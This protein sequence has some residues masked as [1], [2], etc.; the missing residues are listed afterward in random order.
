VNILMIFSGSIACGKACDA[1][2]RLVKAGHTVQTVA[3]TSA[4][5]FIGPALL[6]GISGRPCLRQL[7]GE[8]HQMDHLAWGRWADLVLVAPAT[9]NL[10]N[11]MAA[12][13]SDDLASCL[14]LA[15]PFPKPLWVAPAMNCRMWDHPATRATCRTLANWGV[16]FLGPQD[17]ALACGDIGPG[18]MMEAD[19]IAAAIA[20]LTA[21]APATQP[22]GPAVRWLI[23]AGGTEVPIDAVRCIGNTSTGQSGAQLADALARRGDSVTLLRAQRAASAT[24]SAV[25]NAEFRTPDDLDAAL[26][27]LLGDQPFDVV[28]HM[29]AV[30]D[31]SVA[32][33]EV[34][35]VNYPPSA[36]T[37]LQSTAD[38]R[39]VLR[40]APKI[41]DQLRGYGARRIVAFKLTSSD[42]PVANLEAA[43]RLFRNSGPDLVVLNNLA[44]VRPADDPL[45]HRMTL[46][47]AGE[48][49]AEL[50]SIE[51]L[52]HALVDWAHHSLTNSPCP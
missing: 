31:F 8:A 40:P 13:I 3:T 36:T 4:L 20:A 23:T 46:L 32:G 44:A 45:R 29:A 2:S 15:H 7:F 43:R 28:V 12:G 35:G 22:S 16:H 34:D 6:E 37:K 51:D 9:A 50:A 5:Q 1:L 25:A 17:G 14:L 21:Q 48:P 11:K 10:L 30:S 41:L 39:L 24:H 19:Q 42:D 47:T 33:Y 49:Q 52:A 38:C 27:K 18:R 26:R